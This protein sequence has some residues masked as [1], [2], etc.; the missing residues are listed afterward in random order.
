M[1]KQAYNL[2]STSDKIKKFKI[3]TASL[4]TAG[5]PILVSQTGAGGVV[6]CS[7]GDREDPD[8]LLQPAPLGL[9]R[10]RARVAVRQRPFQEGSVLDRLAGIQKRGDFLEQRVLLRHGSPVF[11]GFQAPVWAASPIF[12]FRKT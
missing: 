9:E 7:A 5:V 8:L 12:D 1:A 10:E 11:A 4:A 2:S 6:A 3:G